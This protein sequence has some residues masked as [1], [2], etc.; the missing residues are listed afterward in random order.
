MKD[1]GP[2]KHHYVPQFLLK[3][4]CVGK[5][6]RIYVFDKKESIVFAS[7]IRDAA[8]ENSFYQDDGL[9]YEIDTESKLATLESKCAPIIE[10]IVS[11]ESIKNVGK[12][13]HSLLC[14]LTTVQLTR[15]NNTR[16]FLASTN[17]I[18]ADW[19]RQSGFDPNKDIENFQ[20]QTKSEIDESAI[21]ILR[22]IPGDLAEHLLDKECRLLKCPK[23]EHFYISD[24]PITMHNH[25]PRPG[26]G[27]H[28]LRLKGIE[29]YYPL[30]SKL[31]L[32]FICADTIREIR[33]KVH[34]HNMR[35]SLG[36]AFPIDM[37]KAE[38]FI[39]EIDNKV[40]KVLEPENVE[41]Q[42]SI[43]VSQS[44]RFI[45][46]KDKEFELAKDMIRTNPELGEP[47][48]LCSNKN[49]F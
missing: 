15:T 19:F 25:Y 41:F 20:E 24:H 2:K 28:G 39:N 43:Q 12:F 30:S 14:L 49:A 27:N 16:E 26:R 29:I 35:I 8:H 11:E 21:N 45:Y 40:T 4:F 1:S 38:E 36:T 22:S 6:K 34:D 10:K 23:G 9:G 31:C 5:K 32:T 13:E 42:N 46:S 18:M 7:H 44:S 47:I 37:S 48:E 3:N 17:K 33:S